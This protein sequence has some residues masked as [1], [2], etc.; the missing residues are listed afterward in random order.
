MMPVGRINDTGAWNF[1]CAIDSRTFTRHD[2]AV[3]GLNDSKNSD[4]RRQY[5]NQNRLM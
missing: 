5:N 4:H 1:E 3:V 2:H